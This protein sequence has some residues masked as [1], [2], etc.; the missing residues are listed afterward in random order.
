VSVE[1]AVTCI[2]SGA[3]VLPEAG[4]KVNLKYWPDAG[5]G[6]IEPVPEAT[7]NDVAV[8]EIA[9]ASVVAA[10]LVHCN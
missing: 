3:G 1:T 5:D 8:D 7:L 9:T 2:I 4:F 6:K 10:L